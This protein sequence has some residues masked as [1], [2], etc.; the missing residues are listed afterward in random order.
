MNDGKDNALK[1]LELGRGFTGSRVGLFG[2]I[3]QVRQ[4]QANAE[5]G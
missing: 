4:C 1:A 2:R 3:L 5:E